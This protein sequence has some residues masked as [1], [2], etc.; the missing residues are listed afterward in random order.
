MYPAQRAQQWGSKQLLTSN[1]NCNHYRRVISYDNWVD[2][3]NFNLDNDD[4]TSC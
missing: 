4:E 1:E 3:W 2:I